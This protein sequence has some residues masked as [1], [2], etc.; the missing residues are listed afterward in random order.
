VS[1]LTLDLQRQAPRRAVVVVHSRRSKTLVIH[2]V[3]DVRCLERQ[4][5]I[6]IDLVV[7]CRI[8]ADISRRFQGVVVVVEAADR[9][10]AS[11]DLKSLQEILMKL[12]AEP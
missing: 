11:T 6:G 8:D 9:G 3:E 5:D 4:I 10:Q 12:V 2:L 1:D 7:Q